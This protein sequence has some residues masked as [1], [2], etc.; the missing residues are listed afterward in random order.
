M[1][2]IEAILFCCDAVNFPFF[3]TEYFIRK[4]CQIDSQTLKMS[5]RKVADEKKER[6][7]TR[8]QDTIKSRW[9]ERKAN[10]KLMH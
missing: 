3:R 6:Y 10:T 8:V 2:A 5:K 1:K 4:I 9:E 7:A